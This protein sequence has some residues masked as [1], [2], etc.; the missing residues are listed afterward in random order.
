MFVLHLVIIFLSIFSVLLDLRQKSCHYSEN[1]QSSGN[2]LTRTLSVRKA[3]VCLRKC[4]VCR[5]SHK[6][7]PYV[8]KDCITSLESFTVLLDRPWVIHQALFHKQNINCP[9]KWLQAFTGLKRLMPKPFYF[10]GSIMN[11]DSE[12]LCTF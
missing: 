6:K 1:V 3:S 7:P 4:S 11:V 10:A 9:S 2:A 8:Y 5:E 12:S